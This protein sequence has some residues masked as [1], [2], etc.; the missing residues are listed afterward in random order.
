MDKL[1]YPEK[2]ELP[3]DGLYVLAHHTRGQVPIA[4]KSKNY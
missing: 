2:G 1:Y 3:E 4:R